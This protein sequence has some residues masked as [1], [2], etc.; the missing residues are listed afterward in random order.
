[1]SG[2][3]QSGFEITD[4]VFSASECDELAGQLRSSNVLRSRAGIRHLFSLP[5]VSD[6]AGDSRLLAI[7][8]GALG[9]EAFAFRATLFDKSAASNWSVAWHQ[10]AT[11]PMQ[12][13]F[14]ADGWGPWSVKSGVQYAGAPACV[15]DRI[16]ALRIH[17][18]ESTATNGPLRVLPATHRLGVL[19]EAEIA[20]LAYHS[21]KVGCL[22]SRGGVLSMKP[23]LI[24]ASSRIAVSALR[25]VLHIE[26][27][28]DLQVAPGIFL[29]TA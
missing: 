20:G 15:L 6:V 4:G 13:R 16:V 5:F 12:N 22:V 10:D 14:E 29:A 23:L 26:Y 17:L 27:A 3:E 24:H 7:A 21:P 11:L 9:S 19:S 25:R 2:I 8:T 28:A 1:V 18:D